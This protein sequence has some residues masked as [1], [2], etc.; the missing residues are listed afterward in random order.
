MLKLLT[1]F[2]MLLIFILPV[3]SYEQTTYNALLSAYKQNKINSALKL[4]KKINGEGNLTAS[5][6]LLQYEI[7]KKANKLQE[8]KEA[9][10]SAVKLDEDCFEAYIG[11]MILSLENNDPDEAKKYFDKVLE[12]NPELSESSDILYYYAKICIMNKDFNSAL[13]SIL[14]AIKLNGDEKL[15][16]LELGKIYLYKKDYI[17]AVN[18]LDFAI[19]EDGKINE[20]VYNYL[21]LSN[22]KRGNP[23][24]ALE[25]FL[26]AV[27]IND[28]SFVYLNNL[29]LCYKSL[30]E[31]EKFKM[32][33]KKIMSLTPAAPSDYVQLSALY[34][35]RKDFEA[36]KNILNEGIKLY[37]DNLLL[38]EILKKLNKT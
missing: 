26:K 2:F 28:K 11:L 30:N 22:Y 31:T 37:P 6:Y 38:K 14:E 1:F 27:E 5:V 21:G 8:A 19:G 16:Y 12:I 17:K 4:I 32:T 15:Y 29:A 20:E 25:Y 18:A 24:R 35:D 3:F 10:L 33:V 7:Y 34:Y 13:D 9:L 23:A 36:A